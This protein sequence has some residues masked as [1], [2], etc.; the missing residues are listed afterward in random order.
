MFQTRT[1]R[2][3]SILAGF[4]LAAIPLVLEGS[5]AHAQPGVCTMPI[6][7]HINIRWSA[8]FVVHEAH[9]DL[10]GCRGKMTVR[11]FNSERRRTETISQTMIVRNTANG[12]LLLGY[13][14]VWLNT[15]TRHPSYAADN[16]LIQQRP[17]GSMG[18]MLCDDLNQCSPVEVLS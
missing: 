7:D 12:I 4:V 3:L 1:H 9:L 11:F 16:I 14:P 13:N 15:R 18:I 2:S 6:Y 8:G 17:D 5:P 10:Q